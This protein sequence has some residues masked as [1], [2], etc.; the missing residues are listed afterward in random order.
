MNTCWVC[1]AF[2]D[3]KEHKIK[4]SDLKLLYPLINQKS[5]VYQRTNGGKIRSLGSYNSNGFK[6]YNSICQKCNNSLTQRSDRAW[7][8]FSA[9]IKNNWSMVLD[10]GFIDVIKI[11]GLQNLKNLILLQ[12]YFAKL[13]GCKIKE[14]KLKFDSCLQDLSKSIRDETENSNLYL[15]FRPSQNKYSDSY[16]ATSDIEVRRIKDRISYVHF[17]IT[18]GSFSVDIL[19]SSDTT[20]INL[21]GGKTPSVLIQEGKI[22]LTTG[23]YDQQYS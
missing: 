5:P 13:M 21:N 22:H 16:S 6:F 15:S 20:D 19:Y 3:S 10:E 7:D 11:Y 9:Y 23:S 1:G 14:S 8:I 2:A 4:K 18:L 12:L 17:F